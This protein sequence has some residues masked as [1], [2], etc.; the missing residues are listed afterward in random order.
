MREKLDFR[1]VITRLGEDDAN[2]IERRYFPMFT[3]RA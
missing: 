1:H 2:L 3:V